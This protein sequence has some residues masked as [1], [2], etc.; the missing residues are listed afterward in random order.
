MNQSQYVDS[1]AKN[2]L[3]SSRAL[4]SLSTAD[5]DHVLQRV[6][7]IL[8]LKTPEILAANL[9][10]LALAQQ[11]ELPKAM[12]DRLTLTPQRIEDMAK[13]VEEIAAFPDPL[14]R[15][16]ESRVMANGAALSR[17]ST[18]IGGVLFIYESRPNVT[19]DGA[20]LCFKSGNAVILR[21]GKESAASSAV[22]ADI[23]R[24][25]LSESKMDAD[26]V[27]LVNTADREVVRLMLERSDALDLVI[28]RGGEGLIRTVVAQ[29][30][31]PVIK[32]YK[33]VCHIYVDQS[34]DLSKAEAILVNAKVQRPSACNAMETLLLDAHLPKSA[35]TRLLQV[36]R[37]KGVVLHG[38][39]ETCK[40]LS[41]VIP[42]SDNEQYNTEYL[43]LQCSVRIVQ[44]V[45]EACDHIE[46]YGSNHT[47]SV[48]AQNMAVQDYFLAEV[49]SSSVMVN[50]STRL[51]DG[52]VYGLGAEVGISTDKLHA[53]GPMGVESLCTYKWIV[54]GDGQVR[55]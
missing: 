52:G 40:L 43:D 12:V 31:I 45:Q 21:G 19:I 11:Q 34:A 1:L 32:H 25:A 9:Q 27:Q 33:G 10:D 26:A 41:E 35:Q 6:A 14:N 17:V 54:R 13:A 48:L 39:P 4:R 53:R 49:G 28:P 2:V 8:R 30:K 22:L 36:L 24:L 50:A 38:C 3:R 47:E 7:E 42:I 5:R 18:P 15:V 46:Q 37:E 20:A 23:F 55:V 16:I 44:D 29:S 51:A